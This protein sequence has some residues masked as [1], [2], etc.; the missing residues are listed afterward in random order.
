MEYLHHTGIIAPYR[1]FLLILGI[2]LGVKNLAL[3]KKG[4]IE[5]IRGN[6]NLTHR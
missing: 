1:T 6:T 3:K 2:I 4:E 5:F